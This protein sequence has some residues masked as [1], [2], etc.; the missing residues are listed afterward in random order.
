MK[1][2]RRKYSHLWKDC[3][4]RGQRAQ[5]VG[6]EDTW[7]KLPE[8]LEEDTP[9]KTRP[10]KTPPGRAASSPRGKATAIRPVFQSTAS[11][12]EAMIG[13]ML[14]IDDKYSGCIEEND[15]VDSGAPSDDAQYAWFAC[16]TCCR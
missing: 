1:S 11:V 8:S 12:V 7:R 4:H 10:G 14:W 9:G 13:P 16:R 15:I 6:E 5:S 3:V 2:I